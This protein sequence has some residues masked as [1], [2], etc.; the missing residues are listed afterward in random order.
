MQI[1]TST[2]SS[3]PEGKPIS[4]RSIPG[5]C[6]HLDPYQPQGSNWNALEARLIHPVSANLFL[7]V[8]YTWSHDLITYTN[9]SYTVVDP[10]HPSRYYGNAE[11]LNFLQNASIT[12]VWNLP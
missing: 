6:R 9:A 3:M 1:T 12:A 5:V 10:Y 11:G 4:L 8:A 2:Q 7:T